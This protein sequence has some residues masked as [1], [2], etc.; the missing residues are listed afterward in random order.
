MQYTVGGPWN[1]HLIHII[2]DYYVVIVIE[3]FF[4]FIICFWV[5]KLL[6]HRKTFDIGPIFYKAKFYREW[7]SLRPGQ[8][9]K[10]PDNQ[11]YRCSCPTDNHKSVA[12]THLCTCIPKPCSKYG[13]PK[14]WTDN[15]LFFR[16]SN[17]VD[18]HL[19]GYLFSHE[20]PN[21]QLRIVEWFQAIYH[22][23][24]FVLQQDTS[25]HTLSL[26]P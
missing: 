11:K 5:S 24:S 9:K 2:N 10:S 8:P 21:R 6:F 7:L 25:F 3:L 1:Q 23:T 16:N 12:K 22:T 17:T 14:P 15:H 20:A 18:I 4:C 13:Q 26:I 19:I